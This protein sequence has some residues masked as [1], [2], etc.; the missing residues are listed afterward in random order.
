MEELLSGLGMFPLKVLGADKRGLGILPAVKMIRETFA[1]KIPFT[2]SCL[3]LVKKATIPKIDQPQKLALSFGYLSKSYLTGV[4]TA[5]LDLK[6]RPVAEV[7]STP[8][9]L[10]AL[11]TERVSYTASL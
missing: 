10:H 11:F 5:E 8:G 3:L 7:F 9:N 4:R 2:L 6:L 1:P